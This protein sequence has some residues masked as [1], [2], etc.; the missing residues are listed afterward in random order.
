WDQS[1]KNHE[2]VVEAI[3]P[4][5]A[6]CP[7]AH[8]VFVGDGWGEAGEE[9]RQSIIE[10]VRKKGLSKHVSFLGHRDDVPYLIP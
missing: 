6:E 3:S 1:I 2:T 10:L 4:V 9:Y 8:F 5:V 7:A